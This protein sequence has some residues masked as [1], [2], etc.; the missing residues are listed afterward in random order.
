M[1]LHTLVLALALATTFAA[2]LLVVSNGE[3]YVMDEDMMDDSQD[4]TT[5]VD[6]ESPSARQ[7]AVR[8]V[9][10]QRT[11]LPGL[12]GF[13]YGGLGGYGGFGGL[14][15]GGLGYGGL[16]YGGLGYGGLG[17]G[18]FGYGGLG[19]GG[20]GGL[21]GFFDENQETTED[22][23][24][25]QENVI[26]IPG[27]AIKKLV[28]KMKGS[29][30]GEEMENQGTD[31]ENQG[32]DMMTQGGDMTTQGGDM[33]TQGGETTTQ[34]GGDLTE[35]PQPQAPQKSSDRF[36]LLRKYHKSNKNTEIIA[37]P[38]HL[39]RRLMRKVSKYDNK[40]NREANNV[41]IVRV[42]HKY[43]ESLEKQQPKSQRKII[44]IRPSSMES[45]NDFE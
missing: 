4:D 45:M 38:H 11:I 32:G 22:G 37:I 34:G 36:K 14:G 15:Y 13:G 39:F 25:G 33:T 44:V 31:M 35:A 9:T 27:S 1:Y 24:T 16:G 2:K 8:R 5:P 12:G 41:E 3:P 43:F 7:L 18:G 23:Q 19:Y 29:G 6:D 20:F 40:F 30:E 21:G 17:Y 42:P 26:R 10:A 28:L